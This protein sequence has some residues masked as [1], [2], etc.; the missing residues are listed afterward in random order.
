MAT[1]RST[2]N[3]EKTTASITM[4]TALNQSGV[5]YQ[6][7]RRDNVVTSVAVPI[8]VLI[9]ITVTLIVVVVGIVVVVKC[10]RKQKKQ[11]KCSGHHH[12]GLGNQ[13][14]VI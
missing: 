13:L 6:N 7:A 1:E 3:D 14:L 5:N 9:I 11:R 4:T 10:R 2:S 8:S 12:I